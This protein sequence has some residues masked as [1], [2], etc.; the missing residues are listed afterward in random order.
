MPR[1]PPIQ[2]S[3]SQASLTPNVPPIQESTSQAPPM[4]SLPPIQ[5][6]P[7][8][9]PGPSSVT[10]ALMNLAPPP[11]QLGLTEL[12]ELGRPKRQAPKR[13][14]DACLALQFQD[15]EKEGERRRLQLEAA[16]QKRQRKK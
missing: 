12:A 10:E 1:V 4:P 9:N 5:D 6:I 16:R 13:K 3:T 8:S 14:L 11:G 7:T 2:E 15:A